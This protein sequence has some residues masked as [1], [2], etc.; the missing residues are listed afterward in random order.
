[1]RE[2]QWFQDRVKKY[3]ESKQPDQFEYVWHP[4]S[5]DELKSELRTIIANHCNLIRVEIYSACTNGSVALKFFVKFDD[6]VKYL[7]MWLEY[8]D[9]ND[10]VVFDENDTINMKYQK[11]SIKVEQLLT[12]LLIWTDIWFENKFIDD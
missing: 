12:I 4:E 2:D 11:I 10:D 1:M 7:F 8:V 3:N 9:F 5:T 6:F